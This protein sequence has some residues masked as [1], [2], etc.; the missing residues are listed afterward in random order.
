MKQSI[1]ITAFILCWIIFLPQVKSQEIYQTKNGDMIITT[2]STNDTIFKV[3][4]KKLF[5]LLNYENAEFEMKMDKSDFLTNNDSLN[6]QLALMKFEIITF[7]GK[8]DIDKINTNGHSPLDFNVEGM[9]STNNKI[10]KGTGRLEHISN[11]STFS[12]L[13][14]LK[15]N[16]KKDEL[17]LNMGDFASYLKEDIQIDIIQ[18]VLNKAKNQ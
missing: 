11:R 4:T 15:F 7:K 18:I 8:L 17:G 9:L 3:I 12:C 6:K 1:Y 10:I 16:L 2:V 5:V 13:L 14:T